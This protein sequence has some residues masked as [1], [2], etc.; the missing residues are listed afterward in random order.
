MVA[1]MTDNP[2]PIAA[3]LWA[4]TAVS[5]VGGSI[6]GAKALSDYVSERREVA[7]TAAQQQQTA[8]NVQQIQTQMLLEQITPLLVV[9]TIAMAGIGVFLLTRSEQ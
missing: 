6:W 2:L 9:G 4:V 7:Q 3:A 5:A 1:E 8:A